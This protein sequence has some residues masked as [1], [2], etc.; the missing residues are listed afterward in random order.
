MGGEKHPL[1][2]AE[3]DDSELA[4]APARPVGP[5]RRPPPTPARARAAAAD[6]TGRGGGAWDERGGGGGAAGG[7]VAAAAAGEAPAR[8]P[9]KVQV[10][11]SKRRACAPAAEADSAAKRPR[12]ELSGS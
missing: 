3:R 12:A 1:S 5:A 6:A 9:E 8:E 2:F 10:N 11:S 4:A 7:G